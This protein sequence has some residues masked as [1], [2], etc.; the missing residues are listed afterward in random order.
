MNEDD[1]SSGTK[2]ALNHSL[3][4]YLRANFYSTSGGVW[5]VYIRNYPFMASKM[6]VLEMIQSSYPYLRSTMV[7]FPFVRDH[8]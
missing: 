5:R 7:Q 1:L 6:R 8:I 4:L 2:L 3:E